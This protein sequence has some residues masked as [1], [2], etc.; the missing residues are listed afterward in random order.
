MEIM[1]QSRG[2][3]RQPPVILILRAYTRYSEEAGT[4]DAD[5]LSLVTFNKIS[6]GNRDMMHND[7]LSI[8]YYS[9]GDLLLADGG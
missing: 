2:H 9:R 4:D 5:W 1:H 3:S 7:Q 8:E 6:Q